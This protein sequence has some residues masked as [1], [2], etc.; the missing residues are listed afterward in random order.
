[1]NWRRSVW[2]C[3]ELGFLLAISC[4][5]T[6]QPYWLAWMVL[7]TRALSWP[8]I[9]EM[10]RPIWPN[11]SDDSTNFLFQHRWALHRKT[12]FDQKK[13][14]QTIEKDEAMFISWGNF[15]DPMPFYSREEREKN[16]KKRQIQHDNQ[17]NSHTYLE[18]I[19]YHVPYAVWH[20]AAHSYADQIPVGVVLNVFGKA[21]WCDLMQTTI[22]IIS[23]KST[24]KCY[25][26]ASEIGE[27]MIVWLHIFRIF[28]FFS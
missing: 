26:M 6:S 10:H 27:F 21:G 13:E 14:Q 7:D 11:Q 4:P 16:R 9:L 23:W 18:C 28:L 3:M 1:M 15:S 19:S 12:K 22:T 20:F 5:Y 25:V 17:I 2:C 24:Q 8:H